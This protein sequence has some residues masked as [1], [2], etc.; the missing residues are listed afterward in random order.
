V[1]R[2]SKVIAVAVA[3]TV[4]FVL[5]HP[6]TPG[7]VAPKGGKLCDVAAMIAPHVT[8]TELIKCESTRLA[9]T[10][11]RSPVDDLGFE[12]LITILLC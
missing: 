6:I 1:T 11:Y 12:P 5:L 4:L 3:M 8:T 10:Q 7:V 2:V 9:A